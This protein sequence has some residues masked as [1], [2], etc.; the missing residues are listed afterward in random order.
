VRWGQTPLTT[1]G[2]AQAM[3]VFRPDLFD[4]AVAAPAA[5]SLPP[6]GIGAFDGPPFDPNNIETYLDALRRRTS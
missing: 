3:K 1:G 5:T 6:D 4:A 2:P